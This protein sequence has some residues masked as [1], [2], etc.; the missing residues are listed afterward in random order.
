MTTSTQTDDRAAANAQQPQLD[1]AEGPAPRRLPLVSGYVRERPLGAYAVLAAAYA[2]LTAA[3]VATAVRRRGFTQPGLADGALLAVAA[4][5]LSRLASKAKITSF[6]RA[7]FTR[8]V[9]EGDGAEVN[10]A[11]RGEGLR[12]ATGELLS[13]PFCM[14]QWSATVLAVSYLHAPRATRAASSLLAATAAADALH[15]A[16]TRLESQA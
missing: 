3:G 7:P 5:R 13:C 11:P 4:F 6:A 10:E 8:F 14:T 12:R 2:T 16:W 15:A 1:D 9:E